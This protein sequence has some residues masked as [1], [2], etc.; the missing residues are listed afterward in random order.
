MTRIVV[1]TNVLIRYLIRPSNAVRTLIETLWLGGIVQMVSAPEIIAEL[2][3]VLSRDKLRRYISAEDGNVLLTTVAQLAEILL[4]LGEVPSY[5]R[6][7][8]DDKFIACALLGQVG[9]LISLDL[10]LLV[11]EHIGDIAIVTPERFLAELS[12][13]T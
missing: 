13:S 7:P 5:S 8:K 2:E 9:Y 10:D 1:D 11:L 6:D 12:S 3:D 4:P